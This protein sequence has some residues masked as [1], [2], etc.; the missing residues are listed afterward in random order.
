MA[1]AKENPW[2]PSGGVL[3]VAVVAAIVAAVLLNVYIGLIEAPYEVTVPFLVLKKD[4]PKGEALEEG[5]LAVVEIPEPLL[6]NN[7]FG[8]FVR[9]SGRGCGGR[10]AGAQ[11]SARRLRDD[12]D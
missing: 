8:R 9:L 11:G 1:K 10:G 5:H 3:I 6:R 7:A 2:I 12:D 4:V